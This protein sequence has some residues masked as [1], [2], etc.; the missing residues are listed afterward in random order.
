MCSDLISC[1]AERKKGT[2]E[3]FYDDTTPDCLLLFF[4]RSVL[5]LLA[6]SVPASEEFTWGH[7]GLLTYHGQ[8]LFP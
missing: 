3:N 4:S 7:M 1:T 8:K 6:E 5:L 2:I